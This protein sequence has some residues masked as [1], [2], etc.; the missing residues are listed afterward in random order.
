MKNT[1]KFGGLR[2]AEG[3][4]VGQKKVQQVMLLAW[5]FEVV[6]AAVMARIWRC[7]IDTAQSTLNRLVRKKIL[8]RGDHGQLPFSCFMLTKFGA[9]QASQIMPRWARVGPPATQRSKLTKSPQHDILSLHLM[10]N[11]RGKMIVERTYQPDVDCFEI[12]TDRILRANEIKVAGG[13]LADVQ[14]RAVDPEGASLSWCCEQQQSVES[15]AKIERRIA[16]YAKA[17][18]EDDGVECVVLGSTNPGVLAAYADVLA[19]QSVRSWWYNN[20]QKRWFPGHEAEAI[21]LEGIRERFIF[22]DMSDLHGRYYGQ[23]AKPL[24]SVDFGL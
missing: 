4:R 21:E 9:E 23:S 8:Q 19:N 24:Q 18:H 22:H 13:L 5:C 10:L 6:D 16:L 11:V 7:K 15:E 12:L 2:G 17:L 1:S 14:C 3:R 20:D